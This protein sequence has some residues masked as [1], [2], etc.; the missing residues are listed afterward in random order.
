K[1]M[2]Q[3]GRVR[4]LE[5]EDLATLRV[6]SGHHVLDRP[7]LSRGVHRL[8]DQQDRVAVGCIEQL[9]QLAE[10]RHL[11]LEKALVVLLGLVHRRRSGWPLLQIYPLPRQYAEIVGIHLHPGPPVAWVARLA[12]FFPARR[13]PSSLTHV[14]RARYGREASTFGSVGRANAQVNCALSFDSRLGSGTA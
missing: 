3:L 8:K 4:M 12:T 1:I 10:L 11:L 13:D 6:H 9:L 7:I 14:L 5:A 2:L